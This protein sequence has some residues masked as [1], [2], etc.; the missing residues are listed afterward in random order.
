MVFESNS[1]NETKNFAIKFSKTIKLG[2]IIA[3]FQNK[4]IEYETNMYQ[5]MKWKFGNKT[6]K[7]RNF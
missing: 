6:K 4:N 3:Y 7:L 5:K 2:K 1:M